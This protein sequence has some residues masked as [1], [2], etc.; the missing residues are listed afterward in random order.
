MASRA[1]IESY[2]ADA[3]LCAELNRYRQATHW[4][5]R[6]DV[7]PFLVAYFLPKPYRQQKLPFQTLSFTLTRC[8]LP[9]FA[10]APGC[11]GAWGPA[12][13]RTPRAFRA[14][15]RPFGGPGLYVGR[16]AAG[17]RPLCQPRGCP[18]DGTTGNELH[19]KGIDPA[20]GASPLSPASL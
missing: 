18:P 20:E 17:R 3:G 10:L 6:T 12:V 11:A 8:P 16:D 13:R 9:S 7:A 15:R 14:R 5:N 1:P 19:T 4:P 2:I